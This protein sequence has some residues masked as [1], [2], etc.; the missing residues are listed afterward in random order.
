LGIDDRQTFKAALVDAGVDWRKYFPYRRLDFWEI[1][2]LIRYIATHHKNDIELTRKGIE[3]ADP[4]FLEEITFKAVVAK[5]TG[6][7]LYRDIE[8]EVGSLY[9]AVFIAGYD[10]ADFGNAGT[11]E[12]DEQDKL[13][14]EL[15][16]YLEG[17]APEVAQY[18]ISDVIRDYMLKN[19]L[20][21][22]AFYSSE[23]EMEKLLRHVSKKLK[24]TV[25]AKEIRPL[26][27]NFLHR[28]PHAFS[29]RKT[30]PSLLLD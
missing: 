21:P 14:R 9:R 18:P 22:D 26:I 12:P 6:K 13:L 30:C 24:R 27:A 3:G 10:P 28:L 1:I 11:F 7:N 5:R 16:S 23:K 19:K 8:M 4:Q 29:W 20:Y 15:T 17:D 2:K 25:E